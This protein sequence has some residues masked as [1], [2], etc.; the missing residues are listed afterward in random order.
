MSSSDDG[1][2]AFPLAW[3]ERNAYGVE[4]PSLVAGMSL[5]D[6]FAGQALAGLIAQS[7][8]SAFGSDQIAGARWAY[9]MSD[10]MLAARK[11][12]AS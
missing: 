5:R 1:G 6:W 3:T 4:F 7:A 12:S 10:A 11:G 2:P 9:Q 8:G